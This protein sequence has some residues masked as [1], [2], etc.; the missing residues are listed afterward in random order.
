MDTH[1]R[2]VNKC[3]IDMK[4]RSRPAVNVAQV[5]ASMRHEKSERAG[6][7]KW[8]MERH[9]QQVTSEKYLKLWNVHDIRSLSV[10][11]VTRG[12]KG[13]SDEKSK[14]TPLTQSEREKKHRAAGERRRAMSGKA[15]VQYSSSSSV[16]QSELRYWD[17]NTHQTHTLYTLTHTHPPSPGAGKRVCARAHM[18]AC[19]CA[20][21]KEQTISGNKIKNVLS[22]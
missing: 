7:W 15:S 22:P 6:R 5:W 13:V 17:R 12:W 18:W 1:T 11:A 20:Q 2:W 10:E 9:K 19:V 16:L 3:K 14:V 8:L 21:Q 4:H